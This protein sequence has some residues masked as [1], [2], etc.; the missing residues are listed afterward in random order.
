MCVKTFILNFED[1]SE[2]LF[3][4]FWTTGYFLKCLKKKI[5]FIVILKFILDLLDLIQLFCETWRGKKEMF[6]RI[7][8]QRENVELTVLSDI[9]V[10]TVVRVVNWFS[11]SSS[12]PVQSF[13]WDA[14]LSIWK[15]ISILWAHRLWWFF[16]SVPEIF[17]TKWWWW[18]C[19]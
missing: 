5:Q 14:H 13:L 17:Q 12:A 15:E 9:D 6:T 4:S 10:I 2:F 3:C 16:S 19:V 7:I 8:T 1:D 11:S 18:R